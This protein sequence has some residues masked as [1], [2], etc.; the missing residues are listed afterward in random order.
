MSSIIDNRDG[1]TLLNGLQLMSAS[2]RE[3]RTATAF[4]S[5]DALLML[6]D[7][8]SSYDRIRIL[9]GD[10]SDADVLV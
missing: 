9:F 1:N 5:L 10:D 4:F 3:L 7:T 8:I 2:G 6:A